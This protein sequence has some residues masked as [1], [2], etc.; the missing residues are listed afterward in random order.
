MPK[1]EYHFIGEIHQQAHAI[2]DTL[3]AE[4]DNLRGIAERL[5]GQ[6][7]RVIMVGC[8]DP[9]F[10]AHGAVYPLEAWARLPAE[11]VEA[12]EFCFYRHEL[13]DKRTLVMLISSS[14]KTAQAVEAGRLARERGAPTLAL[15]NIPYSP[16]TDGA[17][18][19]I[20]TRAKISYSFPTKTTTAALAALCALALE[21][22]RARETLPAAERE[23]LA[24]CLGQGVPEG[25]VQA[26]GLE[27]QMREL[28]AAWQERTHFAYIGTGPGYTAALVGAAKIHETCRIQAEADLLEEYGHLHVFA[29]QQDTPIFFLSPSARVEA[30]ARPMIEYTLN[31]GNEVVI[32]A[33]ASARAHWRDVNI[34]FVGLPELPELLSPLV[35]VVPLQLFAYHQALVRKTNPDRPMGFDNVALQKLIYTGLLEGWQ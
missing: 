29:V 11:A 28:A 4:A 33:P 15:T 18:H 7:D 17:D 9:Y 14:G 32:L 22:A 19:T 30:R 3:T 20:V 5:A 21:L 26:F 35:Y 25:M 10:A 2:R 23:N 34:H 16:V 27:P 13:I 12:L 8:G 24:W 1:D 6:V 31:R